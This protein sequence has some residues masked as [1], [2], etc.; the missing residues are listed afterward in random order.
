MTSKLIHLIHNYSTLIAVFIWLLLF[1]KLILA[2]AKGNRPEIR[3][4]LKYIVNTVAFFFAYAIYF[5][6]AIIVHAPRGKTRDESLTMLRD[7]VARQALEWTVWGLLFVLFM[8]A[9][10]IVYQSKIERIRNRNQIAILT[11]IHL[12]II[13]FA[14][15]LGTQNAMVGLTEEINRHIYTMHFLRF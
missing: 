2:V 1:L 3:N 6:F 5:S 14:I 15:F 7:F 8:F 13:A 11:L 4:S 9:F 10:N 12:F